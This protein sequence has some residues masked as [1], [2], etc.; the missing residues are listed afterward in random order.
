[1]LS[2]TRI[3]WSYWT[4]SPLGTPRLREGFPGDFHRIQAKSPFFFFAREPASTG[5]NR[6][7]RNRTDRPRK[8]SHESIRRLRVIAME[9]RRYARCRHVLFRLLSSEYNT[10]ARECN[11]LVSGPRSS[12]SIPWADGA[13]RCRTSESEA[14]PFEIVLRDFRRCGFQPR[15]IPNLPARAAGAPHFLLLPS[16]FVLPAKRRARVDF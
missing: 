8:H 7:E 15:P 12:C 9:I 2:S 11:S 16:D 4:A 14:K 13:A 6:V 5:R 1:M 3:I 10:L